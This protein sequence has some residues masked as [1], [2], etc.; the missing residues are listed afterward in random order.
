LRQGQAV[1]LKKARARAARAFFGALEHDPE[2]HALRPRPDRG[3]RFSLATNPKRLRGDHARTKR[4][5]HDQ[6]SKG[7]A[8]SVF[9]RKPA[10][11]LDSGVGPGS[12]KRKRVKTKSWSLLRSDSIG[13][14]EARAPVSCERSCR[15]CRSAS[16]PG[17]PPR[18]GRDQGRRNGRGTTC[19]RPWR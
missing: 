15:K 5:D 13:A 12:R 10:S 14:E 2:Q 18:P 17:K 7:C 19:G 4:S 6:D 3:N 11:D 1:W 9:Q 8:Q 16:A